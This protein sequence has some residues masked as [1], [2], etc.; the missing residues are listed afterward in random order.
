MPT[1]AELPGWEQVGINTLDA[2][3]TAAFVGIAALMV[4]HHFENKANESGNNVNSNI[5]RV[6]RCAR[7]MLDSW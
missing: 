1:S 3:V 7:H 4:V 5:R 6:R 2:I